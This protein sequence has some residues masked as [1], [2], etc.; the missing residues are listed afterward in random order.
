[1]NDSYF[2]DTNIFVYTFDNE[3]LDKRKIS[4]D[5]VR[6]ALESF[7]GF[8]SSQVIQEFLNVAT[9]K[10]KVPLKTEDCRLYLENVLAPLCAIY[11]DIKLYKLGLEIKK[12]TQFSFYDSLILASAVILKCRIVYSEDMQNNYKYENLIIKNPFI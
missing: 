12:K 9:R 1:M 5:L 6:N 2:I 10:F 3:S 8:I 7:K 4:R 11:P